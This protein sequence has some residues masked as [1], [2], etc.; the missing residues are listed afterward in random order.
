MPMSRYPGAKPP[1]PQIPTPRLSP[2]LSP[3]PAPPPPNRGSVGRPNLDPNSPDYGI[4]ADP[5]RQGPPLEEMRAADLNRRTG[6]YVPPQ[7]IKPTRPN[8]MGFPD[9][10]P[11]IPGRSDRGPGSGGA[12]GFNPRTGNYVPPPPPRPPAPLTGGQL[13][14]SGV[15][16]QRAIT[17]RFGDKFKNLSGLFKKGGAVT[18]KAKAKAP[19]KKAMGG[20]VAAK[21]MGKPVMK[22]AGGRVAAKPMMKGRKK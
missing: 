15:D 19:V 21:P 2:R 20:K 6:N 9:R 22:K 12:P 1:P 11:S 7:Q 14:Q 13:V 5:V 8:V 18:A 3:P 17:E 10:P 16:K 4:T